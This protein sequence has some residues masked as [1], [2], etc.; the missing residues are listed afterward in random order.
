[1]KGRS[2]NTTPMS[3]RRSMAPPVPRWSSSRRW[4]VSALLCVPMLFAIGVPARAATELETAIADALE[5]STAFPDVPADVDEAA[6]YKIQ[7][8]A[9]AASFG[10]QIAGYKAGLTNRAMQHRFDTD[11]PVIGALPET[12]RLG[13]DAVIRAVPG[14]K[15]EVEI[16]FLIGAD[17]APATMFA[18]IELP[19]LDYPNMKAVTLADVIATDVSA[20]RY[21][22]GPSAVPDPDVRQT[23]VSL[24]KDGAKVF[25]AFA[26]DAMDDPGKSYDW[27]IGKA[28]SLGYPIRRGMIVITGAL[29]RVVDADPGV[30]TAHYG[31]LGD[32]KFT[33]EASGP[34]SGTS[35]TSDRTPAPAVAPAPA[36]DHAPEPDDAERH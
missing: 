30:Y 20:Y 21:I 11:Q 1:M 19:R 35:A 4:V 10:G 12:G 22:V 25:A 7:A 16:G 27:T 32:V 33:I 18:A 8:N 6:A 9:V 17:G 36:I 3:P 28:R 29:G 34:T 13:P 26:S 5:N 2:C 31:A 14:L 15:I 24:D 23:E